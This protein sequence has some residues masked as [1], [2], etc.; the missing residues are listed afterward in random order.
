MGVKVCLTLKLLG[1]EAALDGARLGASMVAGAATQDAFEHARAFAHNGMGAFALTVVGVCQMSATTFEAGNKHG[2]LLA[3]VGGMADV[4][5]ATALAEDWGV[6][7]V[8][9]ANSLSLKPSFL[10]RS[11]IPGV[12]FPFLDIALSSCPLARFASC[13]TFLLPPILP[14][15]MLLV[16]LS[17]AAPFC[18]HWTTPI[19]CWTRVA[20]TP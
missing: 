3:G 18:C 17:F 12:S 6:T 14:I 1:F 15:L 16:P 10:A 11:A 9:P 4:V 5:A 8:M 19:A 13:S 2:W 7:G 20:P